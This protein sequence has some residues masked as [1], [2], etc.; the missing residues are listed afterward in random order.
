[1]L[2]SSHVIAL[3]YELDFETDA[4]AL[5][6]IG[7][8]GLSLELSPFIWAALATSARRFYVLR[9]LGSRSI[10]SFAA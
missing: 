3:L 10:V 2:C 5:G 9:P 7:R 8:M 1:M 4:C 6:G